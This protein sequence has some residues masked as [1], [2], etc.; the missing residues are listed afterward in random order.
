M[1]KKITKILIIILLALSG[2]QFKLQA[3]ENEET[4]NDQWIG[5]N[6]GYGMNLG[7]SNYNHEVNFFKIQYY[8]TIYSG[9]A[10]LEFL[11]QAEHN[12]GYHQLLNESFI[13]PWVEDYIDKRELFTRRRQVNEY[14]LNLGLHLRYYLTDNFSLTGLVSVGP[15]IANTDTE[16]QAKGFAFS[17]NFFL[18]ISYNFQKFR[19]DIRSGHRHVSN[20]N[21]SQPNDG[22]NT[23]NIECGIS[24]KF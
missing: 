19:I 14:V 11:M 8:K 23:A 18:G 1:M 22:H 4:A 5:F 17:D 15:L 7:N 9:I 16:R 3:Q 2:N 21:L 24:M 12:R 20:A 10:D 13:L 6:Y